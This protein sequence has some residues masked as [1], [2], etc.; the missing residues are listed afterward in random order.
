M[1]AF[2]PLRLTKTYEMSVPD[3]DERIFSLLCP[4]REYEWL[5]YW[6]CN[7]IYS[8]SGIAEE[9]C[10]FMTDFP[11]RGE[12]I[13]YVTKYDP[14]KAIQYT[15]FKPGSHI[16]NIEILLVPQDAEQTRVTWHHTFTG[17]TQEGNRFLSEYTDESHRLHL[18]RIERALVHFVKTG[19]MID[20]P[21]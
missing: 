14:P 8:N 20:E 11:G 18:G 13:W 5:P 19:K 1:T 4:V 9:G 12:M 2:K 15:I 6:S 10:L 21:E 16:W 3:R 17:V 7:L